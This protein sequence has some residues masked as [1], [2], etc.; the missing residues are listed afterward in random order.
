MVQLGQPGYAEA[1]IPRGHFDDLLWSFVTIF[2]VLTGENWNTIMYDG[3]R[4]G[5]WMA[6]IY[7]VSLVILLW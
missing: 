6:T 4:A 5:G 7:F 3:W 2:Q 1:E